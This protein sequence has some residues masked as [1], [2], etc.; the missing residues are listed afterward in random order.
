MKKKIVSAHIY[1][2]ASHCVNGFDELVF[3]K[4]LTASYAHERSL[5]L[6]CCSLP[7]GGNFFRIW[8]EL[9]VVDVS[10]VFIEFLVFC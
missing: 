4:F 2:E 6:L 8:T 7:G 3:M 10:R 1:Q 9:D 5:E